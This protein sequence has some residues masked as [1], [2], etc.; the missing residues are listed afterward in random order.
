[1]MF[2]HCST[3]C[4]Y[5]FLASG[6]LC[7][8]ITY[9]QRALLTL[10]EPGPGRTVKYWDPLRSDLAFTRSKFTSPKICYLCNRMLRFREFFPEQCSAISPLRKSLR[11]DP[12]E[13]PPP[14]CTLYGPGPETDWNPDWWC[15]RLRTKACWDFHH[16]Q[17]VW[18]SNKTM[19]KRDWWGSVAAR[20]LTLAQ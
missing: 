13:N 5:Q 4:Q 9:L 16:L 1:M 6:C 20:L 14:P 10:I 15:T 8:R 3:A 7:S 19:G 11:A 18:N 2:V 17:V 12:T